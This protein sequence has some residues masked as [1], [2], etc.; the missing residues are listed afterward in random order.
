MNR[1]A[2][3]IS[4]RKGVGLLAILVLLTPTS[5]HPADEQKPKDCRAAIG[6]YVTTVTDVAGVFSSRGIITFAPEGIFL[7]TDSGQSRVPGTHEASQPLQGAWRCV[8]AEG[9][10]LKIIATG[11]GFVLPRDGRLRTFGRADYH[12]TID[13]GAGTI[14]GNLELSL[15]QNDDLEGADPI[16]SPGPPIERFE[17]D[18]RR[19]VP[20]EPSFG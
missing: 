14:S 4:G 18:G 1:S 7:M 8:T 12:V 6:T 13:G 5:T 10:Q 16:D 3:R 15:P 11:I 9:A 2:E 19:V 20:R 17:L